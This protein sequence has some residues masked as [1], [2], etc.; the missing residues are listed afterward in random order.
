VETEGSD[1]E[2]GRSKDSG[3]DNVV[4]FPGD[5]IGSRDELVPF[6]V[7]P[8][9]AGQ[10]GAPDSDASASRGSRSRRRP[11][12]RPKLRPEFSR[13]RGPA[14][15][16]G[17]PAP[18]PPQP[19]DGAAFWG[20]ESAAV[21][22]AVQGPLFP[23]GRTSRAHRFSLAHSWPGSGLGTRF[24]IASLKPS[25]VAALLLVIVGATVGLIALDHRLNGTRATDIA[26][27]HGHLTPGHSG[28][29]LDRHPAITT[30]S[31]TERTHRAHASAHLRTKTLRPKPSVRRHT[32]A[33]PTRKSA[34]RSDVVPVTYSIQ[35][36][37]PATDS[38]SSGTGTSASS[39]G[40][41]NG[42]SS[43][44]S[45]PPSGG[46]SGSSDS[47]SGGSGSGGGGASNGGGGGGAS[48]GGGS[49][50]PTATKPTSGTKSSGP[51]SP[52]STFGPGS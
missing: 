7:F 25:H 17:T 32:N 36:S 10:P 44:G 41:G 29:R 39:T 21:Q 38:G 2:D 9:E 42:R 47:S 6:G 14:S 1:R 19:H 51:K 45:P 26:S 11:R 52:Y 16:P 50:N 33:K 31:G 20:E 23:D 15:A 12:R 46:S 37:S 3:D 28:I 8:V 35:S 27:S 34:T 49:S 43:T 24:P 40:T 13:R 5:W 48:N 4:P 18:T 22:D 30:H